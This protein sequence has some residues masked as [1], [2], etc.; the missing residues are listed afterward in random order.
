[1]IPVQPLMNYS[2]WIQQV[3]RSRAID[4][5]P[6]LRQFNWTDVWW[7]VQGGFYVFSLLERFA[8]EY[9][10]LIAVFF[11]SIAVSWIYGK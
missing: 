4:D 6:V 10:I 5:D 11:E 2:Y 3:M 8:A 7:R 1:M 9:S